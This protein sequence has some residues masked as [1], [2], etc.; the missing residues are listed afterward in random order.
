MIMDGQIFV[1]SAPSGAGKSTI[2]DA[3]MKRVGRHN[4]FRLTYQPPTAREGTKRR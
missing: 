2:A 3:L 1:L 4:L